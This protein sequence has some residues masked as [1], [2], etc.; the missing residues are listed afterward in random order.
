MTDPTEQVRREMLET[1]QPYVDLARADR[2]WDTDA[3]RKE[4][5]VLMFAAPFVVVR[6]L[7]DGVRG[8]LMFT[9]HPRWY[10]DFRVDP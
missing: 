8:T 4:F 10:F 1:N 2:R 9:H 5:E 6:R 7:A 3:L